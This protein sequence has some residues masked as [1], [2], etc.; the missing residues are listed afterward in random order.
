MTKLN[1][2]ICYDDISVTSSLPNLHH[3]IFEFWAAPI[4]ISSYASALE[5]NTAVLLPPIA[6]RC[7]S[8][9]SLSSFYTLHISWFLVQ[10]W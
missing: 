2:K 4:K 3:R 5:G 1:L 10:I 9:S 7:E 6:A 8:Y